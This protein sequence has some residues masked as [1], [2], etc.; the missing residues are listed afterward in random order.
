MAVILLI[1]L[2]S[3]MTVIAVAIK[4]DSTVYSP[5]KSIYLNSTKL[6]KIGKNDSIYDGDSLIIYH[7]EDCGLIRSNKSGKID[8]TIINIIEYR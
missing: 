8:S 3:P 1:I 6:E 2:V 4:K 7:F 5:D